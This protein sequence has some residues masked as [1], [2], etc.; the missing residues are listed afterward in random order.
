[1][2][3]VVYV[4]RHC[5]ATGQERDAHL[6]SEGMEQAETLSQFLIE[7]PVQR[8]MTSP[9]LRAIES[10]MPYAEKK[11]IIVEQDERLGERVLSSRNDI[12]N[13]LERLEESFKDFSLTL[14]GGESSSEAT[15]R[16]ESLIEDVKKM[17]EE[18]IVL[19]SHG[20]LIT[21]LLKL[22]DENYG[23]S[24]WKAMSNPDIFMVQLTDEKPSV[25]RIWRE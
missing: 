17:K 6:T 24:E 13:W 11:G 23:F 14:E 8:I 25:S 5:K 7:Y 20:N 15:Q 10:I 1:M 19:V 16:V 18:H 21:L 22:F 4:I 3:K 12:S 9:Y 2:R